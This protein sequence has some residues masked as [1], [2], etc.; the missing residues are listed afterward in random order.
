M[1]APDILVLSK[2]TR[3]TSLARA[4][5]LKKRYGTKL[6][7]DLSDNI[8]SKAARTNPARGKTV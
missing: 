6:I 5:K 8:Y 1:P 2:R 7:L 3:L 4:V